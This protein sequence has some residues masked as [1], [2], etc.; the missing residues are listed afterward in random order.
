MRKMFQNGF[1]A[2]FLHIFAFITMFIDHLG[3]NIFYQYPIFRVIGR[4]AFPIFAFFIAEGLNKTKNIKKY[5]LRMFFLCIV[6]E[7]PYNFFLRGKVM[8]FQYNNVMWTYLISVLGIL[9]INKYRSIDKSQARNN[10]MFF[11]VTAICFVIGNIFNVD[12]DGFGC[13]IVFIFYF[14]DS[15]EKYGKIL[16]FSLF[17]LI[18]SIGFTNFTHNIFGLTI[19]IEYF[20]LFSF[21]LIWKYNGE[22]G[23]RNK[24]TKIFF[25]GFYPVHLLILGLV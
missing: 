4:L 18:V 3:Y 16:Q 11:V 22:Q 24:V 5:V 7:I 23:L 14:I 10:L 8:L 9:L 6:S 1:D 21:P 20:A 2:Y 17:A 12:Y 13:L 15:K 25:Y 19:P